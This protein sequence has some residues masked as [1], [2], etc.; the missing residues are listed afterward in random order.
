MNPLPLF[1]YI[2]DLTDIPFSLI[3]YFQVGKRTVENG[4]GNNLLLL[5][6]LLSLLLLLILS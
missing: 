6:L 5:L 3:Y 2:N 4:V 1:S